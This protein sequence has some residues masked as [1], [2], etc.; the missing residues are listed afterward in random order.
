[1]GRSSLE[2]AY[3]PQFK[4]WIVGN[5]KPGLH[6]VDEAIRR[7]FNLVPFRV[8]I[9]RAER[10]PDLAEKLKTDWRGIL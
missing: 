4:L 6:A 7:R 2:A 5:H 8:T 3:K 9:P 1:M 10:D